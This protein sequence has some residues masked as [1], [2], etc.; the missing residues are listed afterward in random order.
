MK[1]YRRRPRLTET[2]KSMMWDRWLQ[3][4]SLHAIARL[5][6]R[7]YGTRALTPLSRAQAAFSEGRTAQAGCARYR[8]THN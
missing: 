4:D 3:G 1:K 6:E 7:S 2:E 8:R 5:Q